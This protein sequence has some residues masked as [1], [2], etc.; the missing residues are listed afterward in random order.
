MRK[1]IFLFLF[2][3]FIVVAGIHAQNRDWANLKRYANSNAELTNTVDKTP[4]VVFMGNSITEGWVN[5]HPDFFKSNGYIGR[6]ISGQTS[7]QFLVRFR[8]DVVDLK[9][10]LVIINAGT[11]D[12]A[13]NTGSYDEDHTFGN[14]V[15]MVEIAKANRI[16]VILT[17]VLPAASFGWNK[18]ITDV[19]DK[20]ASLNVRIGKYAKKHKIPFVDYYTLMVAGD[21][22]ALNPDYTKDGVHPTS[23][24]YAVMEPLIQKAIKKSLHK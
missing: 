8:Q 15:S 1:S 24:G 18:K 17:T 2:A 10:E 13:E 16:K 20:I 3:T 14:I 6:G 22:R 5:N 7:S 23:E 12:V 11:N 4:R 19:A 9:P 21:G